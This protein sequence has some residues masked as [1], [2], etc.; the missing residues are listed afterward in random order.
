MFNA[1]V[2]RVLVK[3]AGNTHEECY[4]ALRVLEDW[5]ANQGE[6]KGKV[7]IPV[8]PADGQS[9]MPDVDVLIG[10]VGSYI[11]DQDFFK[12]YVDAGKKVLLFFD[13][14]NDDSNSLK[15]EVEEVE[16]FKKQMEQICSCICFDYT[17]GFSKALLR[18][19]SGL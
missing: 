16:T 17:P 15:S 6:A 9:P 8:K 13:S 14:V 2:Y 10:I 7:F 18:C 11:S 19:L 12:A 5:N 4:T 3:S 1:N